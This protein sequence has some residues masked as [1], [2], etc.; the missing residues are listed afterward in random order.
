MSKELKRDHERA[1]MRPLDVIG[2]IS[3]RSALLQHSLQDI[4]SERKESHHHLAH[5]GHYF[6][7]QSKTIFLT[8]L[9]VIFY[10]RNKHRHFVL[11]I[12]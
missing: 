4:S 8:V 2:N 7:C 6:R 3:A 9:H 12:W 1:D 11:E 5:H 10:L